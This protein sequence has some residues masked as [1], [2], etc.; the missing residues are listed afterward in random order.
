VLEPSPLAQRSPRDDDQVADLWA[1]ALRRLDVV[2]PS[3]FERAHYI[4]ALHSL[5][6][7]AGVT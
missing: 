5:K 4:K 6:G 3:A 7:A 1:Q 2:D